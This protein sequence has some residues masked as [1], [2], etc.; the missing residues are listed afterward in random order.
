MGELP[1]NLTS[2]QLDAGCG[3]KPSLRKIDTYLSVSLPYEK[4]D[5]EGKFWI[6]WIFQRIPPVTELPTLLEKLEQI[7]RNFLLE[8]AAAG[9]QRNDPEAIH[10]ETRSASVLAIALSRLSKAQ[11]Y[12]T[13]SILQTLADSLVEAGLCESAALALHNQGKIKSFVLS[14]MSLSKYSDEF[15]YLMR[16]R[17]GAAPLSHTVKCQDLSDQG[18]ELALMAEMA[19]ADAIHLDL[20]EADRPN[21]LSIVL[22]SP[23]SNRDLTTEC[24]A[25][26]ELITVSLRHARPIS[27]KRRITR[28]SGGILAL[29][30]AIWLALP[31]PLRITATAIS[32]PLNAQAI[33]LPFEVFLE[34]MLVR[35]GDTVK[36]GDIIARLRAPNIEEQRSEISLQIGIEEITAQAAL[37]SNDYGAYVLS[38]QKIEA[39]QL[40]LKQ[41]EDRLM[42][43]ELRAPHAGRVVSAQGPEV[44]G[45]HLPLGET[46]AMIQPAALFSVSLTVSR[47]DAAHLAKGQLGEV[48]FR[49]LSGQ[50]WDLITE[51]PVIVQT[52][53]ETGS[54]RLTVS[55]RLT[56]ADQ[57][58]LFA[59]LAGFAK[60]DAGESMRVKVLGRYIGE[61]LRTK[62]WKWFDL[63]L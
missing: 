38:K 24:N 58:Q 13:S 35:T 37:S 16:S 17:V 42:Q 40:Q 30:L 46:I 2:G 53:A 54:E 21:G 1:S 44:T 60:I 4:P 31:A 22:I 36:E 11:R 25:L 45:S 62:A 20:P 48:W 7:T 14:D 29:S 10:T 43:M 3:T 34:R 28:I 9:R 26:R 47:V 15:K 52:D 41:I 8:G 51:T 33:A 19:T 49:G 23:P 50:T 61:Y 27:K 57:K 18:F 63:R 56:G 32:R 5:Q 59:G 39:Q 12:K 55:A 6:V